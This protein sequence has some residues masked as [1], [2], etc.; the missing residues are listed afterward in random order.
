MSNST[1]VSAT[2]SVCT[3]AAAKGAEFFTVV[4]EC[5]GGHEEW[6]ECPAFLAG[7]GDEMNMPALKL[8][9]AKILEIDAW[10]IRV[11]DPLSPHGDSW[12]HLHPNCPPSISRT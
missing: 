12:V 3:I 1:T 6:R 8:R 5:V 9:G 2:V 11:S 4:G 10:N 7:V